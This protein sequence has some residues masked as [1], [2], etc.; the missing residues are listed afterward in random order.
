MHQTARQRR[1]I[2]LKLAQQDLQAAP[3]STPVSTRGS[4]SETSSAKRARPSLRSSAPVRLLPLIRVLEYPHSLS[5]DA[6][7]LP[8]S[9]SAGIPGRCRAARSRR[10]RWCGACTHGLC[11]ARCVLH[12]W[13]GRRRRRR[14]KDYGLRRSGRV[15]AP[16]HART[17]RQAADRRDAQRAACSC[18]AQRATCNESFPVGRRRQPI[19][20]DGKH[21]TSRAHHPPASTARNR[22]PEYA[23]PLVCAMVEQAPARLGVPPNPMF[24]RHGAA[25]VLCCA[26]RIISRMPSRTRSSACSRAPQAHVHTRKAYATTV[27]ASARARALLCSGAQPHRRGVRSS[28]GWAERTPARQHQYRAPTRMYSKLLGRLG[29]THSR[30]PAS[31]NRVPRVPCP[32]S[33]MLKAR[34]RRGCT[35]LARLGPVPHWSEP[36]STHAASRRARGR[37]AGSPPPFCVP[38]AGGSGPRRC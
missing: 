4:G 29:R 25:A 24:V 17:Q 26:A 19:R 6:S 2:G 5:P 21:G 30:P 15:C 37:P 12:R 28:S 14:R 16:L 9:C 31:R 32:Y 3:V 7:S 8:S 20:R 34:P 10:R 27:R 38:W 11:D 33:P 1:R 18:N 36:T 22:E 23:H 35:G 13:M